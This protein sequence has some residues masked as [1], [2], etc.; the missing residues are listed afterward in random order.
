MSFI[1]QTLPYDHLVVSDLD[2]LNLNVVIP[3]ANHGSIDTEAALPVFI[4]IHGGGFAIGSSAWP[5]LD[6]ARFVE[7]SAKIGSPVIGVSIK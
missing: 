4:Y 2:G 3:R 5:Q 7:F 6:L 1:Q